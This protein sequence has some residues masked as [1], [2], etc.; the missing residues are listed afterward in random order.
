MFKGYVSKEAKLLLILMALLPL[1]IPTSAQIDNCCFVD[2]QCSTNYDWVSGYYAFLNNHCPSQ[3]QQQQQSTA[4]QPPASASEVID[5]CCFVGWQCAT[6]EEWTNGY[7]AFQNN[8]CGAPT[9]SQ[10]RSIATEEVNN[11]CY[12]GWQC[13]TDEEWV[14]GYFAFQYDQCD[15][16]QSDWQA[17]WRQGLS[18]GWASRNSGQ[19]RIRRSNSNGQPQSSQ[20]REPET[21]SITI[22]PGG[23][24]QQTHTAS[25]GTTVYSSANDPEYMCWLDPRSHWCDQLEYS[26]DRALMCFYYP[27]THWCD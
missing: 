10:S 4:S 22:S 13:S 17:Q 1:S 26:D 3:S 8:Q 24:N 21:I 18:A 9:G 19:G 5:N 23:P 16:S 12:I 7:W 20:N 6:D 25:D 15:A 2:R 27:G 11:C 14:S